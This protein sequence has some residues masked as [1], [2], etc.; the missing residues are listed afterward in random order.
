MGLI[1]DFWHRVGW[2]DLYILYIFLLTIFYLVYRKLDILD[3]IIYLLYIINMIHNLLSS[4]EIE[5]ILNNPIVKINKEKLS[6]LEKVDFSIQLSDI[7]KNKLETGLD[8][9]LTHIA[10]IPMG[11]TTP[12][13]DRGDKHFNNTYLLYL[14]DSIGNLIIDGKSYRITAG[15]AHIFSEGLEHYTIHTR[16]SERLMIGPMSETGSRVGAPSSIL[17]YNN[18][19]DAA[20]GMNTVDSNSGNNYTIKTVN[21]ISSWIILKNINGINPTRNGGPYNTGTTLIGTGVYFLYPYIVTTPRSNSF[22]MRSL[23]TD[24]ALVY[25]KPHSLSSGGGGSGVK[26][27]RHK[28]R[29]T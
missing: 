20:N 16:D 15:D 5:D 28:Q 22:S 3:I 17:Y 27:S 19:T 6:T 23:F 9:D 21:N 4:N 14:T 18:Q 2:T 25:Y 11:D 13:I 26:N 29:R 8:I 12:H 10:S 7:I 1:V 24:N